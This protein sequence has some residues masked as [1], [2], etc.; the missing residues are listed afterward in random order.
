MF[1]IILTRKGAKVK[2]TKYQNFLFTYFTKYVSLLSI[3]I[4]IR[5]VLHPY[6]YH[7]I[8]MRDNVSFYSFPKN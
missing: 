1:E 4:Y 2:T 6:K 5:I 3:Y 8:T 7:L